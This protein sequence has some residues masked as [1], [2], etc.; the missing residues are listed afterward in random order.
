MSTRPSSVRIKTPNMRQTSLPLENLQAWS[1]FNDVQLFDVL[2]EPH[3]IADGV[4]RGGGLLAKADHAEAE[5]LVAVPLDLVLSKQRVEEAAKSDKHLKELI[6]AA[7]SLFQVGAR[8]S[9]SL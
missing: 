4:D 8:Q 3:I 5:P 9:S 1:H 6:E 7:A 2:V